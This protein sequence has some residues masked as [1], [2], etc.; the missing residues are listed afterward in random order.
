MKFEDRYPEVARP[1]IACFTILRS[2]NKVA[3]VLRKNTGWMEGYYGLP[4]GKGE[5]FE[6]FSIGAAREALEEAGV[7]V[8][9][10]KMHFVH[11]AHR[12]DIDRHNGNFTDWVDVYFEAEEW[13]G[14]PYNAEE[15]KSERLDWISLSNLPENIVPPQRAALEEIAKGNYYSEYG[16]DQSRSN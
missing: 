10:D 11:L 8:N 15:E 5:W 4:A 7:N 12:H 6:P 13:E 9:L 2:G 16:W 1:Y 14:E 3:M